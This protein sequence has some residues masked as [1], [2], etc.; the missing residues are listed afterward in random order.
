M[1]N[2]YT[3]YMHTNI[4]N[5]KKYIGITSKK[6]LIRW[7]KGTGYRSNKYFYRAICKY[8]WDD[9]FIHTIIE[10]NLS[11]SKAC[12][13]EIELIAFY[14]SNNPLYGYNLSSGGEKGGLGVKKSKETIEKLRAT[15]HSFVKKPVICIETGITYASITEAS[16]STKI[17][18]K[19]ISKCCYHY[20]KK[21]HGLHWEFVNEKDKT[22]CNI[23]NNNNDELKVVCIE[24]EEIIVLNS[25]IYNKSCKQ[26]IR[27]CCN[28][29]SKTALKLH[30]IYYDEYLKLGDKF[31]LYKE[32]LLK[33]KMRTPKKIVYKKV[34]C[35]D[36]G[37]V[38]NSAKEA[39]EILN[40]KQDSIR[41]CC[42]KRLTNA[43]GL[44]WMYYEDYINNILV[45]SA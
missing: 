6:P 1:N 33:S 3:V 28:G 43:G 17:C 35:L 36:T 29:K 30:W 18:F 10:I 44:L 37:I 8:G 4:I 9:G 34:I 15:D 21:T 19:N 7:E 20:Q 2:N 40:I 13:K 32:N 25:S 42:I 5:N 39:N 27:N 38:Y 22:N 12:K 24:T 31:V 14:Q 23:N 45:K 16:L 41:K 26:S 11:K